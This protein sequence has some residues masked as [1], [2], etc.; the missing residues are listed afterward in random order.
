[1]LIYQNNLQP[2][3]LNDNNNIKLHIESDS[4]TL[5][6]NQIINFNGTINDDYFTFDGIND[7]IEIQSNISPQLSNSDFTIHFWLKQGSLLAPSD[8]PHF[9]RHSNIF[10][11]GNNTSGNI[12]YINYKRLNNNGNYYIEC[13]FGGDNM[14]YDLEILILMKIVVDHYT[15][16]FNSQTRLMKVFIDGL[17][18]I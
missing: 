18:K 9:H 15:I 17:T 10:Y 5:T 6:K 12:I 3:Y 11:V 2:I 4:L 7:F 14:S 16:T 1:M 13:G 8:Y